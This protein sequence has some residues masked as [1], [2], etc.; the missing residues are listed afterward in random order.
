MFLSKASE[1]EIFYYYFMQD[2]EY[3]KTFKKH[4]HYYRLVLIGEL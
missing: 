3:K 1:F 4:L 2:D